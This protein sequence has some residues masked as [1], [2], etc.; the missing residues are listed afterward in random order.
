MKAEMQVAN[1]DEI[2]E[3]MKHLNLKSV[4]AKSKNTYNIQV[5][6]TKNEED[7]TNKNNKNDIKVGAKDN[8]KKVQEVNIKSTPKKDDFKAKEKT[9]AKVEQLGELRARGP[10]RKTKLISHARN[11]TFLYGV[12]PQNIVTPTNGGHVY[13]NPPQNE[14][15]PEIGYSNSLISQASELP[16]DF[17]YLPQSSSIPNDNNQFINNIQE[18]SSLLEILPEAEFQQMTPHTSE[19]PELQSDPD[20]DV[21]EIIKEVTS[22]PVKTENVFNDLLKSSSVLD[23]VQNLTDSQININPYNSYGNISPNLSPQVVPKSQLSPYSISAGSPSAP[24]S[25]NLYANTP[26]FSPNMPSPTGY[27]SDDSSNHMYAPTPLSNS[28]LSTQVQR[29]LSSC[30]ST[31]STTNHSYPDPD[32]I[33][34]NV[35]CFEPPEEGRREKLKILEK[36]LDNT[37]SQACLNSEAMNL[38]LNLPVNSVSMGNSPI[39]I[40]ITAQ[41]PAVIT[42]TSNGSYQGTSRLRKLLPKSDN[43]I[44]TQQDE[45]F[46]AQNLPSRQHVNRNRIVQNRKKTPCTAKDKLLEKCTIEK[47]NKSWAKVHSLHDEDIAKVDKDGDTDLMILVC[48]K[49]VM[50]KLEQLYA[51]VE[52]CKSLPEVLWAKNKCELSALHMACVV[53]KYQPLVVNYLAEAMVEVNA[54]MNTV[55]QEGF[56]LIHLLCKEGDRCSEVLNQLLSMRDSRGKP[57]FDINKYDYEGRSPLHLAIYTHK[58]GSN[59]V[60]CHEI[61]KVLLKNGADVL[62]KDTKQ[63]STPLHFAVA[64]DKAD[65]NLIKTL[66]NSTKNKYELVNSLNY[67]GDTPL[68]VAMACG[69]SIEPK[70]HNCIVECLMGSGASRAIRNQNGKA[71]LELAP[72]LYKAVQVTKNQMESIAYSNASHSQEQQRVLFGVCS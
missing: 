51:L 32:P 61:V 3:C 8:A 23:Q 4:S 54:D 56:T 28:I 5:D 59:Y 7:T 50:N 20:I 26:S 35:I 60:L 30:S 45:A 71:P 48:D 53:E 41:T 18:I 15:C 43:F 49:D 10:D 57:Y 2:T 39:V 66:C 9:A 24:D 63:G 52:R 11:S 47:I 21:K 55:N 36:E 27:P 70:T 65:P 1:E 12:Y 67:K 38:P 25:P 19:K 37:C 62:K 29:P 68:H 40:T 46:L 44:P 64:T 14:L 58:R 13:Y 34:L 22:D 42:P 16:Q 31:S 72:E 33:D 6:E 17:N 69:G